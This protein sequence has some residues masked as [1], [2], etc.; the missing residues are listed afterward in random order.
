M[1]PLQINRYKYYFEILDIYN[2]PNLYLMIFKWDWILTRPH[3]VL[4]SNCY[5][6]VSTPKH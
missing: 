5:Q 4:D 1:Y 3:K 2:Q 6:E